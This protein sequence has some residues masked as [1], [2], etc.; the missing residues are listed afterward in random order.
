MIYVKKLEDND[1]VLFTINCHS[2]IYDENHIEIYNSNLIKIIEL[3][4]TIYK[5]YLDDL[6]ETDKYNL[7]ISYIY[8]PITF[9]QK[10]CVIIKDKKKKVFGE[11]WESMLFTNI[12]SNYIKELDKENKST[13]NY[14]IE[15]NYI[16]KIKK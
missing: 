8:Y 9:H 15:D 12:D 10:I 1:S 11:D 14:I 2:I 13:Y 3:Y 16:R 7:K 4:G 6:D 5:K